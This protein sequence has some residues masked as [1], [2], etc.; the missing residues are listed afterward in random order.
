VRWEGVA[1][2][3]SRQQRA[4]S[5]RATR[6]DEDLQSNT[7]TVT[8]TAETNRTN[9][10][11]NRRFGTWSMGISLLVLDARYSYSP[12][13][14]FASLSSGDEAFRFAVSDDSDASNNFRHCHNFLS[15][16]LTRA[17]VSSLLRP[18]ITSSLSVISTSHAIT[19]FNNTSAASSC[20]ASPTASVLPGGNFIERNCRTSSLLKW[21]RHERPICGGVYKNCA[22]V[23]RLSNPHC[24][25]SSII[26]ARESLSK[27]NAPSLISCDKSNPNPHRGRRHDHT[28]KL[29][30]NPAD[31]GNS[32]VVSCE[33]ST[34]GG[35]WDLKYWMG[36]KKFSVFAAKNKAVRIRCF[37]WVVRGVLWR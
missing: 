2:S 29:N 12:F 26:F 8:Q 36:M 18:C 1:D 25:E 22:S 21:N 11:C 27:D 32:R 24:R 19:V 7:T 34:E 37:G 16:P 6:F 3:Q 30:C 5:L 14:F 13:G 35:S 33:V 28:V 31:S 17:T 4:S 23:R 9:F 10:T 20:L 15:I